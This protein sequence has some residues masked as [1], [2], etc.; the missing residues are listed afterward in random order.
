MNHIIPLACSDESFLCGG[1]PWRDYA[2]LTRLGP[3]TF[4]MLFIC[5]YSFNMFIPKWLVPTTRKEGG[6]D[7][8][9]RRERGRQPFHYHAPPDEQ[10]HTVED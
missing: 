4:Q 7:K 2:L 9:K 3:G 10:Q 8:K 1:A 6:E 5:S